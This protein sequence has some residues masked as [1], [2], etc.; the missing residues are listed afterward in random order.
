MAWMFVKIGSGINPPDVVIKNRVE[1]ELERT[2][3]DLERTKQSADKAGLSAKM[4]E[5]KIAAANREIEGWKEKER[6]TQG[7]VKEVQLRFDQIDTENARQRFQLQEIEAQRDNLMRKTQDFEK[8]EEKFK[9][10]KERLMEKAERTEMQYQRAKAEKEGIELNVM[11]LT[12]D[13]EN[14]HQE[15]KELRQLR[16]VE[17]TR[18]W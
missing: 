10:E 8:T 14:L 17:E 18:T 9:M 2:R 5:D 15:H 16:G 7:E 6:R 1:V 11:K 12:R 4:Y 13:L 3:N